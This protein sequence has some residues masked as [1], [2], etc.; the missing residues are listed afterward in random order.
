MF[1]LLTCSS[2]VRAQ[3]LC[4]SGG[5]RPGLPVLSSP[6]GLCG[7]EATFEEGTKAVV[8]IAKE[9]EVTAWSIYSED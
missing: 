6:Y 9:D 8:C 4:E 1:N 3:Q 2:D 5:G 7:R